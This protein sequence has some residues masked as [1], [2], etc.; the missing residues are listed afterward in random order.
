LNASQKGLT[1]L[2]CFIS[3]PFGIDLSSI[4]DILREE[5]IRLICPAAHPTPGITISERITDSISKADLIVDLPPIN[6]P[7]LELECDSY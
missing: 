6:V 1:V 5:G 3:A 2:T 7:P 4:K